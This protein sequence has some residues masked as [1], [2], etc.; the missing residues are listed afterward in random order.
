MKLSDRQERILLVAFCFGLAI[1]LLCRVILYFEVNFDSGYYLLVVRRLLEGA[2]PFKDFPLLYTPLSFYLAALFSWIFDA[3]YFE[4]FIFFVYLFHFLI[5]MLVSYLSFSLGSSFVQSALLGL[6]TFSVSLVFEGTYVA[7]EPFV[8][9]FCLISLYF[10]AFQKQHH[11]RYFFSGIF[12]GLA[13]L[14]KQYGVLFTL[15]ALLYIALQE[16]GKSRLVNSVKFLL[17]CVLILG[18]QVLIW[19]LV[20]DVNIS[21]I[22]QGLSAPHL[23]FKPVGLLNSLLPLIIFCPWLVLLFG[24]ALFQSVPRREY[25]ILIT[26]SCIVF[27]GI[28]LYFR[29]F[30]H[31]HLLLI[32]FCALL[33]G[34]I[35]TRNSSDPL[36]NSLKRVV[37]VCLV[38]GIVVSTTR[39]FLSNNNKLEQEKLVTNLLEN[40]PTNSKVLVV[41]RVELFYL[42]DWEPPDSLYEVYIGNL[43]ATELIQSLSR[44]QYVIMSLDSKHNYLFCD[45]LGCE[46]PGDILTKNYSLLSVVLDQYQIW[47]NNNL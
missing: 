9:I 29:N 24:I 37:I 28:P 21:S 31:Y 20:Y 2:A 10:L 11:W 47:K 39:I 7:L 36:R 40:V 18:L 12:C 1:A 3:P 43:S 42:C 26:L 14:S 27:F 5:A 19:L 16:R 13:I 35:F 34:A 8:A 46:K 23:S 44:A 4:S 45:I 33:T 17:G 6:W 15:P 32:P 38:W 30:L 25:F 41:G 22:L